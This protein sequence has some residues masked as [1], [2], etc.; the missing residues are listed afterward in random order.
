M[1]ELITPDEMARRLGVKVSTVIHWNRVNDWPHTR[2]GNRVR[3]TEE[4]YAE[5][6]TIQARGGRRAGLP[7]QTKLSATR[8][9]SA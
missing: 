1:S 6:L 4:Q 7:G 5:V 2:I 9:R 8:E 3:W